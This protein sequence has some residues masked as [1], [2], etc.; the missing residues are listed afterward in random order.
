LPCV[1]YMCYKIS[2][3]WLGCRQY[4]ERF[5]WMG[6]LQLICYSGQ[7]RKWRSSEWTIFCEIFLCWVQVQLLLNDRHYTSRFG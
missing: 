5:D 2:I 4:Q 7:W 3:W 1:Q 6:R